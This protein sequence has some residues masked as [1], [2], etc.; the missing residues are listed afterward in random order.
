MMENAKTLISFFGPLSIMLFI[1]L[2]IMIRILRSRKKANLERLEKIKAEGRQVTGYLLE[3]HATKYDS[4]DSTTGLNAPGWRATYKYYVFP[5]G[6][7]YKK[8]LNFASS[9]PNSVTLYIDENN[10][11]KAMDG[12]TIRNK[13]KDMW[14]PLLT[15]GG[16]ILFFFLV[17]LFGGLLKI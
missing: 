11:E 6:K 14:G 13:G 10:P 16:F 12:Y 7:M 8:K 17:R 4:N 3:K 15:I 2:P 9:P 1:Y 5:G